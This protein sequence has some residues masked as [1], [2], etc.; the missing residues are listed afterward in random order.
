MQRQKAKENGS[1][2]SMRTHYEF[3]MC[4]GF[5]SLFK[6]KKGEMKSD[7]LRTGILVSFSS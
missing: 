3:G 4:L 7:K 5:F 2:A 6:K 1:D